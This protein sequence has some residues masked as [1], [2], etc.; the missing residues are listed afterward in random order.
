M[1]DMTYTVSM[2][3]PGKVLL[4]LKG[5]VKT[6]PFSSAARVEAGGL[7]RRL[8]RGEL[9]ALPHSRPMPVIGA[10]C[11]ELRIPDA[12]RTWRIV[13]PLDAEAVVIL[14]VFAKT[15]RTTPKTVIDTCTERLKQYRKIMQAK[16]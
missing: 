6:P 15:S 1:S 5:E 8:Q 13:Y 7:L 10:A 12:T 14:D 9:I 3:K 11:H 4:W 16:E 2:L